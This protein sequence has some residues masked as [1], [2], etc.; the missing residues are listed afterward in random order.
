MTLVKAAILF[1]IFATLG[2]LGVHFGWDPEESKVLSH[3]LLGL[4][5]LFVGC[6][7]GVFLIILAKWGLV[8]IDVIIFPQEPG[9]PPPALYRLPEWYISQGRVEEAL[10]EYQ[11]ISKAH[12]REVECWKGMLDVLV[13]HMD[14]VQAARKVAR[15]SIRKVRVKANQDSLR[16]YYQQLTGEHLKIS[17]FDSLF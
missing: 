7:G 16:E 17:F 13:T 12:P 10:L 4:G 3:Y 14:N 2:G 6:A 11:K 1:T 9:D 15:T 5:C 8:L